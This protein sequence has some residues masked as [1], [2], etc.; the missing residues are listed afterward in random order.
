MTEH[1]F[2]IGLDRASRKFDPD[3]GHPPDYPNGRGLAS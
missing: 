3:R 1:R 2:I